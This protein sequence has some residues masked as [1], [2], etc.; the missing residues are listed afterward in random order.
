M[1]W[2]LSIVTISAAGILGWFTLGLLGV[3]IRALLELRHKILEQM[4]VFENITPP[5]PRELAVSSRKINEY[6]QAVRSVREAQRTFRDLGSQLLAFVE[7]EPGAYNALAA[8]GLNVA[9]AGNRLVEFAASYARPDI[10]RAD[11]RR[12]IKKA[13]RATDAAA[14]SRKF[15]GELLALNDSAGGCFG[16]VNPRRL[17]FLVHQSTKTVRRRGI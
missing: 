2:Y 10:D 1:Q 12:Q 4:L 17:S 9:E 11:L 13:L 8:I 5:R 6:D 15:G 14:V 16:Y 3:P 7:N